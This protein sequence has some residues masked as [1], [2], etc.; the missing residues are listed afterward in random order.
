[1]VGELLTRSEHGLV[2]AQPVCRL[3]TVNSDGSIHVV[4]VCPAVVDGVVYVDLQAARH[5]ERNLERDA[6]ATVLFDEYS[7]DWAKLWGVQLRCVAAFLER[8]EEWD[9]AWGAMKVR[10]PQHEAPVPWTP[11]R[12]VRLTPERKV[13][14]GVK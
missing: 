3:A 4:S 1:M 7:S 13:S 2:Q 5:T 11:R 14:W 6:R 12:I 9:R 10:Y 8:G